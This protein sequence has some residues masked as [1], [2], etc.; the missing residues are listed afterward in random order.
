MRQSLWEE[1]T[2]RPSIDLLD[3]RKLRRRSRGKWGEFTIGWVGNVEEDVRRLRT[4]VL[5]RYGK[6]YHESDLLNLFNERFLKTVALRAS[7]RGRRAK[8]PY[9]CLRQSLGV[10]FS[11]KQQEELQK[12]RRG[13]AAVGEASLFVFQ[14]QKVRVDNEWMTRAEWYRRKANGSFFDWGKLREGGE[15]QE[16]EQLD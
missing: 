5:D 16:V 4:E 15:I 11:E 9:V 1:H 10:P 13:V 7:S 3:Y 6:L 12:S 8:L 14:N 2:I